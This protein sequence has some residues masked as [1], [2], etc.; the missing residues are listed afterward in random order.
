M[1]YVFSSFWSSGHFLMELCSNVMLFIGFE[2]PT[3]V[4]MKVAILWDIA[5]CSPYMNE[6]F[7]GTYHLHFQGRKSADQETSVLVGG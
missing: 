7:G 2:V 4:V 1:A 6:R 3:A 5:P